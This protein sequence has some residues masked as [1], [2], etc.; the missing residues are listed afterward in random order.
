M[1]RSHASSA[2]SL[3]N[4]FALLLAAA[5]MVFAL[6]SDAGCAITVTFKNEFNQA[7]T[8]T[9]LES[10]TLPVGKWATVWTGDMT[11]PAGGSRSVATELKLGCAIQGGTRMLRAKYQ[12]GESSGYETKGPVNTAVDR[13]FNIRF[14]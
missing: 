10:K 4:L 6:P 11:V 12:K 9:Q 7:I 5:V 13:R 1:N 2:N 8:V 14:K 3:R